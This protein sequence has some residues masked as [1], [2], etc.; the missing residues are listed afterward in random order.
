M[1]VGVIV[2]IETAKSIL[3]QSSEKELTKLQKEFSWIKPLDMTPIYVDPDMNSENAELYYNIELLNERIK[4][5][6]LKHKAVVI[7]F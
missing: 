7:E 5:I 3:K 6:K 4:S 2:N 1:L